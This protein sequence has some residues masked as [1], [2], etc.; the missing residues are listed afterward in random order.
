MSEIYFLALFNCVNCGKESFLET[1]DTSSRVT[2][3]V[4]PFC[5]QRTAIHGKSDEKTKK[6]RKYSYL[7]NRGGDKRPRARK[8]PS[9]S[10]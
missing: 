9:S 6:L 2:V 10:S 1:E 8:A 7:G 3:A 4:C 5:E